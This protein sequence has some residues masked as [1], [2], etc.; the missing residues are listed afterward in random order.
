MPAN[1]S[2]WGDFYGGHL[3]TDWVFN[4]QYNIFT[5]EKCLNRFNVSSIYGFKDG[6]M[7][8]WT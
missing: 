5:S 3:H 1:I 7:L 2:H 4:K 8:D 6:S